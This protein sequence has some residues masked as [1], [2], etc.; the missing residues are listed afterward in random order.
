MSSIKRWLEGFEKDAF[1]PEVVK[2]LRDK[3]VEWKGKPGSAFIKMKDSAFDILYYEKEPV[4]WS[5]EFRDKFIA[6][7]IIVPEEEMN[8][9]SKKLYRMLKPLEVMLKWKGIIKRKPCFV[10]SPA[11]EM[12][13]ERVMDLTPNN[14]LGKLLERDERITSLLKKVKPADFIVGLKAVDVLS[15]SFTVG[16]VSLGDL[17]YEAYRNPNEVTWYVYLSTKLVRGPLYK[18]EA[19]NVYNLLNYTSKIIRK[20]SQEIQR[21]L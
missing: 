13:M 1:T 11:L 21:D 3:I 7:I 10:P 8:E 5:L 17:E 15:L 9:N 2:A 18:T 20:I 16:N 12:L 6:Q 4:P 19:L 14:R